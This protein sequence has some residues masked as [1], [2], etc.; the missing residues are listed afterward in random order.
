[1]FSVSGNIVLFS[2]GEDERRFRQSR[3]DPRDS[4]VGFDGDVLTASPEIFLGSPIENHC[5][6]ASS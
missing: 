5:S 2:G 4:W 1:M 3:S 6:E